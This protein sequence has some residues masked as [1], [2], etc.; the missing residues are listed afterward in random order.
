LALY[1]VRTG[2]A[3]MMKD[4]LALIHPGREG[5]LDRSE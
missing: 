4:T 1:V 5:H 2:S 3:D